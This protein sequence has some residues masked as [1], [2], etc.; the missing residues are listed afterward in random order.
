M[1]GFFSNPLIVKEMR[2]RF[3]S[4]KSFWILGIYL[5]VMGAILLGFMYV[6][7]LDKSLVPGENR[8]WF[9]LIAGLQYGMICFIAPALSAGTISGERERQTLHVLLTTQLSPLS[10]IWSKLVT[11]LAFI[12]VLVLSSLPLYSFVFLYG[13]MSPQQLA[14]LVLFFGVNILFFGSLGLF[15]STCI[16][17]TGVSTITSYGIAFFF[18]VGTGLLLL[19]IGNLLREIMPAQYPLEEVWQLPALKVLAM[20]NPVVVMGDLFGE[21]I[22]PMSE[23][24]MPPWAAFSMVYVALSIGLIL[25]SGYL[26]RPNRKQRWG[27]KKI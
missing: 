20:L 25:V 11:S 24:P 16:K 5:F 15:C 4:K 14:T 9:I 7:Q 8:E 12:S 26:L 10:I 23:F 3:R 22:G 17:R 1:N 13:G 27:W 21:T 2:E 18:V 6:E 19:F